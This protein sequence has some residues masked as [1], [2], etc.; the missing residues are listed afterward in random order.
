[1]NL[2]T[3]VPNIASWVTSHKHHEHLPMPVLT[4]KNLR[5]ERLGDRLDKKFYK[6][7]YGYFPIKDLFTEEF[8][9][10]MLNGKLVFYERGFI[11]VDKKIN[12][13]V[14]S[15]EDIEEIKFY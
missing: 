8:D 5:C 9:D 13:F 4:E 6:Q 11:F 14:L 1:M 10:I 15:Y 3:N 2:T 12:A 7:L